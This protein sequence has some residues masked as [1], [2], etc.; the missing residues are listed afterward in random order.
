MYKGL[1]QCWSL[2][3]KRTNFLHKDGV[4]G[5]HERR[6]SDDGPPRVTGIAHASAVEVEAVLDIAR[7]SCFDGVNDRA[8]SAMAGRVVAMTTVL[9][10]GQ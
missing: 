3:N 5:D 1:A 2:E 8:A 6:P 10:R 9:V 4:L 7:C